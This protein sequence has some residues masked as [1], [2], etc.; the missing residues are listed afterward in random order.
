VLDLGVQFRQRDFTT[1]EQQDVARYRRVDRRW[2]AAAV[3]GY[4]VTKA[5]T[6]EVRARYTDQDWDRIDPTADSDQLG[7]TESRFGVGVRCKF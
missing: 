5:F 1:D 2:R 7:Y 3:W 6:V 4:D